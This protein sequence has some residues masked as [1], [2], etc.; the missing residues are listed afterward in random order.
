MFH[1]QQGA[2]SSDSGEM[3]LDI[4]ASVPGFTI[5][6]QYHST[7]TGN[8]CSVQ[9]DKKYEHGARKADERIAVDQKEHTATR[10]GRGGAAGP[11]FPVGSCARDPLAFLQFVRNEL[12]QGRLPGSE[13]LVFGSIY[14][15]R[16]VNTG[17]EQVRV[18]EKTVNADHVLATVKGPA[19]DAT[20]EIL[21]AQDASRTPV[22][23]RIPLA[24]GTF[25]VE[26]VH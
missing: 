19:T 14:A 15:V 6:D 8:L 1:N 9:V 5:R 23:A 10:T 25:T 18:G 13:S 22:L 21:F 4:D 26:L 11:S 7:V 12:A 3:S 20:F 2:L 17:V 16:L 24:L